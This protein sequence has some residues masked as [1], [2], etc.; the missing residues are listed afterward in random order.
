MARIIAAFRRVP[1]L[2][3]RS[4]GSRKRASVRSRGKCTHRGKTEDV[5]DDWRE[6]SS[7]SESIWSKRSLARLALFFGDAETCRG[8]FFRQRS[9]FR[10]APENS[11]HLD[12]INAG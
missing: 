11:S 2:S 9:R 6:N 3:L 12:R 10:F 1:S 5:R 7:D 4:F 8:H